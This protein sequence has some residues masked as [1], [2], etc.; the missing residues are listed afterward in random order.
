MTSIPMNPGQIGDYRVYALNSLA[1]AI[2]RSQ[3]QIMQMIKGR[4]V[5][6][7]QTPTSAPQTYQTLNIQDSLAV[8]NPSVF[9]LQNSPF[10]N[11]TNMTQ[12]FN[13][14]Y[15]NFQNKI[16]QTLA[17]YNQEIT[18]QRREYI[19][20]A[21]GEDTGSKYPEIKPRT[22]TE[23]IALRQRQQQALKNMSPEQRDN[24]FQLMR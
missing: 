23:E 4:P 2:Q 1:A 3:Y 11:N 12:F 17:E 16:M 22:A 6:N 21:T 8:S 14:F 9:D 7:P 15:R 13:N 18:Q 19:N 10:A 24:L 20:Q 5:E